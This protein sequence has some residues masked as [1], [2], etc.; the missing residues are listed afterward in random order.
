MPCVIATATELDPRETPSAPVDLD[1]EGPAPT[2]FDAGITFRH[3]G[4]HRDRLKVY[5]A[6]QAAG[7]PQARLERF[8][9]C[10]HNAWVVQHPEDPNIF[11]IHANTCRDRYCLPCGQAR[12][13]TIAANLAAIVS[14][15][16]FRFITLTLKHSDAPLADQVDRL[17]ASFRRLRE[18]A[19]WKA[20]QTGGVTFLEVKRS[21]GDGGWHPHL[22][23]LSR[24]SYLKKRFLSEAWHTVTGDSFIVD[25]TLVKHECEVTRYVTKYASKPMDPSTFR[26][27]DSLLEAIQ[28]LKGRRLVSSFGDLR[29]AQLVLQNDSLD[30]IPVDTLARICVAAKNGDPDAVRIMENLLCQQHPNKS[31]TV[32]QRGPPG[33]G[34]GHSTSTSTD[35]RSAPGVPVPYSPTALPF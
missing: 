19:I 27:A 13:R 9:V 15:G 1:S 29:D 7:F 6:M 12:A 22:H 34:P 26:D 11:R 16:T 31:R 33:T 32:K 2:D 18:T 20:S 14:R 28:S 3:S 24:G 21:A 5:R 25:I 10:G 23:V 35:T 30:W 8:A 4:W 17:F